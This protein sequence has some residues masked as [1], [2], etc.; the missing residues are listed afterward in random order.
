VNDANTAGCPPRRRALRA[1]GTAV[2]AAALG[3]GAG[4]TDA[5]AQGAA[6][7]PR[8]PGTDYPS[9]PVR[10]IVAFAPGG[11]A[12]ITARL[13]SGALSAQTGQQFVVENRPG[14]GGVVAF[15]ALAQAPPDGHTI[16]VGAL[17]THALNLGLYRNLPVHPLTGVENITVSSLAPLALVVKPA[18]P[19]RTLGEFRDLLRREPGRYQYGSPGSGATGHIAAALLLHQLGVEALHVPYRGSAP[20]FNDLLAGR[21]DFMVDTV[22]FVAPH[23]QQGAVR[24]IVIGAKER[25]P[26]LP[27]VPSAPEAGLPQYEASTWT[28]WSAPEGTPE[29]IVR[30][31]YEQIQAALRNDE[32]LAR[33]REL[34]NEPMPGMTPE[35]T[36]EFIAG[37]IEKW[38]PIVRATGATVD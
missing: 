6:A 17:S 37:E 21:I 29:A 2:A 19:A 1:A 25:S 10:V 11:N 20:A 9:R 7:P 15:Q 32:V 5:A 22:S 12:D 24:A 18:L 30:F 33:L 28:P 8:A 23:V 16:F 13:I 26:L 14:G 36:R 27:E 35:R 3:L 4:P 31:L 38:V 34:G